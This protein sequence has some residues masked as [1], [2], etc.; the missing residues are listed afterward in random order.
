MDPYLSFMRFHNFTEK[1]GFVSY[2]LG[3]EKLVL[4]YLVITEYF[5][6]FTFGL[7]TKYFG[8]QHL[9]DSHLKSK[10]NGHVRLG[11]IEKW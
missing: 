6:V 10:S 2:F 4:L 7:T 3:T 9:L 5:T 8:P 11:G 1:E